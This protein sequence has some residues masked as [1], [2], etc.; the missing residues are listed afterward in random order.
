MRSP[1]PLAL[2]ACVAALQLWARAGQAAPPWVDRPLTLPSGD[3]TFDLGLGVGHVP[4]P[5][6]N[7]GDVGLGV[8]AEMGVGLTSHVE[9]GLRTGLRFGD[10]VDRGINADAY[11]RLFDRQTFDAGGDVLANPELRVRGALVREHVVE[12]ALEGRLVLPF[13]DG[14]AAGMM[15]G[16]PM[17]FHLGSAVRL[18]LGAYL[19]V[20]FFRDDTVVALRIP[21]DLWIQVGPRLWLGP[22]TGVAFDR[23][24]DNNGS[25]S[26]SLGFGLGYEIARFVDLKTMFLFP[27]IN[28]ESRIFGAGVGLQFRIE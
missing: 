27:A 8:N 11:G 7:G 6:N 10:D 18:D 20:V 9:L 2:L 1:K 12:L 21:L 5:G 23:L 25:T 24:G 26:V 4:D 28:D 17:A 13:A 14:T 19:P 15:F 16:V 3:W 22:M